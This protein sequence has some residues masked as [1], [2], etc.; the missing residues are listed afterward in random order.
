MIGLLP[1]RTVLDGWSTIQDAAGWGGLELG[2]VRCVTCG[3]G[4]QNPSSLQ[5]LAVTPTE[6]F[7]QALTNAKRGTRALSETERA[8][9]SRGSSRGLINTLTTGAKLKI[10][11][12]Q[13]IDQGCDFEVEL[14]QAVDLQR[15]RARLVSIQGDN[16]SRKKRSQMPS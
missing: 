7:E 15:M 3:L 12:S 5:I 1:D 4:D 16:H 8:Q 9:W 11:M 10:K 13:I 2:L 14:L 6:I